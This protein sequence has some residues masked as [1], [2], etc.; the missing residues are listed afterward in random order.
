MS[1]DST[2]EFEKRRNVP[3]RYNRELVQTTV[4]AMKRIAE[5]K[6]KREHAFWKN[7]YVLPFHK[8]CTSILITS[9][10]Q[11]GRRPRKA[12]GAPRQDEGGAQGEGLCKIGRADGWRRVHLPHPRK[13]QGAG[14]EEP[15]RPCTRRWAVY[16][17]GCGLITLGVRLGRDSPFTYSLALHLTPSSLLVVVIHRIRVSIS[18]GCAGRTRRDSSLV[19]SKVHLSQF[20]H[21]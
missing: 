15:E 18:T 11:H 16:G 13:D 5:I 8:S 19:E 6:Q 4:K 7:R 9:P 21:C 2:I 12:E 10:L 20:S 1:Q 17:D 3:V 14:Q